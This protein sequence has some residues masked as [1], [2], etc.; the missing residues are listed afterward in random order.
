MYV[1]CA[2]TDHTVRVWSVHDGT[3]VSVL[4]H[5]SPVQ[6]A[7]FSPDNLLIV[8][9]TLERGLAV[10]NFPDT[11]KLPCQNIGFKDHVHTFCFSPDGEYFA[12]GCLSGNVLIFQV[13]DNQLLSESPVK[14]L[15]SNFEAIENVQFSLD[16]SL[17]VCASTKQTVIWKLDKTL[18]PNSGNESYCMID[19]GF[20]DLI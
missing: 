3:T 19:G 7:A 9:A 4:M 13:L 1:V 10:W 16:G 20:V 5:D 12:A 17:L 18:N 14:T 15:T 2:S 8:S 6:F 11:K